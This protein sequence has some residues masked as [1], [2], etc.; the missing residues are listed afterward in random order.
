MI[1][2]SMQLFQCER[3]IHLLGPVPPASYTE[4]RVERWEIHID[5]SRPVSYVLSVILR[6]LAHNG[7]HRLTL[8][9]K[10]DVSKTNLPEV[11]PSLGDT[12]CCRRRG[13]QRQI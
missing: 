12:R 10:L 4:R 8:C 1:N 9:K 2:N 6:H 13:F 11:E 7:I 3:V 5:Q